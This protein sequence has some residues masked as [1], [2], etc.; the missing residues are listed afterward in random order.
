MQTAATEL[1]APALVTTA[2]ML[3]ESASLHETLGSISAD[4][5]VRRRAAQRGSLRR[6]LYSQLT[7]RAAALTGPGSLEPPCVASAN[8]LAILK[9]LVCGEIELAARRL[10]RF[11]A[12]LVD[13]IAHL[14]ARHQLSAGT[15]SV[16]R[17][18][19][20]LL[21]E[22]TPDKEESLSRRARQ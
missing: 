12:E 4:V 18:A 22:V 14:I 17:L 20:S 11:D 19:A 3:R 8:Y 15:T 2:E 9:C 13:S 6:G 1:D 21:F 16:L 7:T 5:A 10:Q